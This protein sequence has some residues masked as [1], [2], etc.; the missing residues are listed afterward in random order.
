MVQK[1]KPAARTEQ[2]NPQVIPKALLA[3]EVQRMIVQKGLSQTAAA[4]VVRDA[5]SQISLLM[6]GHLRG[7]SAD[8]LLRMLLHLGCDVDIVIKS[9]SRPRRSGRVRVLRGK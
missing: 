9:S 6:S 3:R 2:R 7:F 4:A 8:R 1:R 5:A